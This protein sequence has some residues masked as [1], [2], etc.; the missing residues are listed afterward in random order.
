MILDGVWKATD[1]IFTD[2]EFAKPEFDD[3][4][5]ADIAVPS[6]WQTNEKFQHY[7]E[8]MLFRTRFNSKA[9]AEKRRLFIRFNGVFYF[10]RAWLNGVYLGEHTGYF[11][12]FEFEITSCVAD[13]ENTL[14]V[15]VRCEIERDLD[16]KKQALGVFANWDCKPDWIQPGGIWN[17]VELVETGPVSIEHIN[18]G[19]FRISGD[20][21]SGLA[22][23][24]LRRAAAPPP[25]DIK[26]HLKIEPDNFDAAATEVE[27]MFSE[28]FPEYGER[29]FE[30]HIPNARLWWPHG[31]GEQPL[32]RLTA[33]LTLG[34]D[35]LD[36][37][38]VRFGVRT[39]EMKDW[40]MYVNGRRIFCRGSNYA[41]G[42]IRI[43][44]V[45]RELYEKDVELMLNANLNMIR[46]HAH[47][48]RREFYDICDER[49][50]LLWQDFPLQWYYAREVA[51]PA[52]Q[53]IAAMAKLLMSHP[54]VAVWC[55]HN[56]PFKS[57]PII[58]KV[59][60]FLE[61]DN[62]PRFVTGVSSTLGPKNW[63]RDVL[64]KRLRETIGRVDGSRPIVPSSGVSPL[65]GEGADS[66]LYFGW[67]IGQM[68]MLEP[69]CAMDRKLLRFITEYGAQAYPSQESFRRIQNVDSLKDIDWY[70]LEKRHMLQRY[71]MDQYTPESGELNEYIEAS[72]A[73]QARLIKYYNEYFRKLK[74]KP[75]SGAV[76]FMF[77][78]CCP[79][80]T[81]SVLDY[82]RIPKKGYDAL[83]E[84]FRPLHVM[85]DFP[86]SDYKRGAT[87]T[88]QVYAV[89]DFFVSYPD[90]EVGWEIADA[91]GRCFNEG[92]RHVNIPEDSVI[93]TGRVRW[94]SKSAPAG[95]Y[96]LALTLNPG[97]GEQ[98]IT[99]N[100]EFELR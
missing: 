19:D 57:I 75:C 30:F 32:Y 11:D 59:K 25:F 96:T 22:R 14:T 17:S 85:S 100:Y 9:H 42:D 34:G 72:Q 12:P 80:I 60:E 76:H 10:C 38:S 71:R 90:A 78:D 89:N 29:S 91:S 92:L 88:L 44:D 63:N 4:A 53:Q 3:S 35:E 8:K 54:S 83:K 66:H 2:V 79:T 46:V 13:G 49:G 84:S 7:P 18:A 77:N 31:N 41:P 68:Q 70:E 16:R 21:A 24:T 93:R 26:L 1:Q 81:W 28:T 73:Y 74:Y 39:I 47:V 36:S 99:N 15:F 33:R 50:I 5:W 94:S 37:A 61:K 62:L 56:E 6:H 64:D 48:E 20:S 51:V 95:S 69:F 23:I 87:I 52:E 97:G 40:K 43:A 82:W 45:K 98:A 65:F 67:Y 58:Y 86:K 55:C 27:F